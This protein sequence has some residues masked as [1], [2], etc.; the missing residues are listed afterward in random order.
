MEINRNPLHVTNS[1][2]A[3]IEAF[4][5]ELVD[6]FR[7]DHSAIA[8]KEHFYTN[9]NTVARFSVAREFKKEKIIEMWTNWIK[10]YEDYRPDLISEQEEMVSK[11]HTSGKYRYCGYDKWGCPVLVIRMRYH[12]KGLAEADENLRY[13]LY[14]IEK[15]VKL[16]EE[17]S[18]PVPMQ[19]P[20]S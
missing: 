20:T 11:I 8:E 18:T 4:Q 17:A 15:G 5:K 13:L 6:I 7:K 10:W 9:I 12:I 3:Q 1:E 14:M 19:R 2:L 16:A